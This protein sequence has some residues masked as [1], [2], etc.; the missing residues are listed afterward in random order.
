VIIQ[1][2][3]VYK[4]HLTKAAREILLAVSQ[5]VIFESLLA[6]IPPFTDVTTKRLFT[7]VNACVN[8]QAA[9]LCKRPWT[10]ATPKTLFT[11]VNTCAIIEFDSL[12]KIKKRNLILDRK[13]IFVRGQLF[14]LIQKVE[15]WWFLIGYCF[16]LREK[17]VA[18]CNK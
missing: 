9:L 15:T 2:K 16:Q 7:S 17:T 18:V 11:D 1:G 5:H 14:C 6:C 4:L 13:Q 10:N 3:I 8:I 12:R